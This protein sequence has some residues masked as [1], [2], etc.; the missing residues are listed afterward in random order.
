MA[1]RA[2]AKPSRY[3]Q[4][5][6]PANCFG[7]SAREWKKWTPD[8]RETFNELYVAM[9]L[10]KQVNGH[11]KAAQI[12]P[13]AWDTIRHN[14]AWL[15]ASDL[16][17]RQKQRGLPN[18]VAIRLGLSTLFQVAPKLSVRAIRIYDRA[19]SEASKGGDLTMAMNK[20]KPGK[21]GGKGC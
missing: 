7:V 19:M 4:N 17:H 6:T 20:P 1:A 13:T 15:A 5:G 9:G 11:P 12:D 21:K 18:M 8:A 10:Q 2:K 14:A 16:S 3:N